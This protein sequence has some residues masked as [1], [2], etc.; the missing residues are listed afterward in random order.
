MEES[1][2]LV[3]GIDYKNCFASSQHSYLSQNNEFY[4]RYFVRAILPS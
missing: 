4:Y 1:F 2:S 3:R